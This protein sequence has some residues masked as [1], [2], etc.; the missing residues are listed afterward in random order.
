[1]RKAKF[2][3]LLLPA[4]LIIAIAGTPFR[5]RAQTSESVASER[6][7][8]SPGINI[9]IQRGDTSLL[10]KL[11]SNFQ[12]ARD[13]FSIFMPRHQLPEI[14][15][16]VDSSKDSIILDISTASIK[17]KRR[18][19]RVFVNTEMESPRQF[20]YQ[21]PFSMLDFNRVD[22]FFL[23][24]GSSSMVDFGKHDEL[25]VNLGGGYG[26]ENKR[27]QYFLG[28]EYRIPLAKESALPLN[29]PNMKYRFYIPPTLAIGAEFHNQTSTDDS[30]RAKR[31]ENAL[32]AFFAREDFRDYYKLAGWSGYLALRPMRNAEFRAEWRSDH[33][34]SVEQDVFYG[35][36][37]G[38]KRLPVNPQISDG[39]LN[40]LVLTWHEEHV[41]HATALTTN[42]FGDS[43]Q[44]EQISGTSSILQAEFGHMPNVDFGFNR[45]LL[46]A[47]DF[48]PI[49]TGIAWDTRFRFQAT[50][51]D[52]TYQ[53]AEFLGGPSSLPALMN[54][55]VAGNRLMLLNTELRLSM[56]ELFTFIHSRELQLIVMN[57]F[58][59]VGST[60]E[61]SIFKGFEGLTF[62]TILY[63]VGVA[64]GEVNSGEIGVSWR[65]DRKENP[66][67]MFRLERPF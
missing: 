27:W 29:E 40:S 53:K 45:Y 37:G 34:E 32:Y 55:E 52:V 30:W 17:R 13:P 50:T 51:G 9:E 59:Y 66:R 61:S 6:S 19:G 3:Q 1:M 11:I 56:S 26:F 16:S 36:W 10:S 67:F 25:G 54:K 62:N 33:Y 39:Q 28:S 18:R 63:N 8:T 65:T 57:D 23:G 46:D 44:I 42:V 7:G 21:E 38:N 12:S 14:D 64:I 43:V 24:F 35:R 58:G 2:L 49:F 41:K 48:R 4:L 20:A 15:S 60:I 22:G 47:R 5:L 31:G